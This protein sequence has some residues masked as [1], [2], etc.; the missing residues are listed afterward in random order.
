MPPFLQTAPGMRILATNPRDGAG[1]Y[2][3]VAENTSEYVRKV[4]FNFRVV[5]NIKFTRGT[6]ITTDY[7]APKTR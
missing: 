1:D 3:F 4:D 5:K 2:I 7:L 6:G